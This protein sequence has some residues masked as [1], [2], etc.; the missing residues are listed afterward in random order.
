MSNF[1]RHIVKDS[2]S[3]LCWISCRYFSTPHINPPRKRNMCLLT[4]C[5]DLMQ[6]HS[7]IKLTLSGVLLIFILTMHLTALLLWITPMNLRNFLS[8]LLLFSLALK[9]WLSKKAFMVNKLGTN[10][11]SLACRRLRKFS[12]KGW[13]FKWHSDKIKLHWHGKVRRSRSHIVILWTRRRPARSTQFSF[14]LMASRLHSSL[15]WQ[16]D[17]PS[18]QHFVAWKCFLLPYF[19]ASEIIT[20]SLSTS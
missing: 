5:W 7:A 9:G 11:I 1:L 13:L 3:V 16:L 6:V 4:S 8:L 10:Y 2:F 15:N 17:L 12:W 20:Y 14:S 19:T 18:N